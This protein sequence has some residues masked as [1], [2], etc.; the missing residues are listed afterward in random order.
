MSSL[1]GQKI[2]L[3][4][5]FFRGSFKDLVYRK[6]ISKLF[7]PPYDET[8]SSLP[9][10]KDL[11][12]EKINS[13][14]EIYLIQ[15]ES[16]N[17]QEFQELQ[18]FRQTFTGKITA[19]YPQFPPD[20]SRQVMNF[21][22]SIIT[23]SLGQ[24]NSLKG[25]CN[26]NYIKYL[27]SSLAMIQNSKKPKIR[28]DVRIGIILPESCDRGIIRKAVDHLAAEGYIL[29]GLTED[30]IHKGTFREGKSKGSRE[31]VGNDGSKGSD[32]TDRNMADKNDRKGQLQQLQEI[33]RQC[34]IFMI[35]TPKSL[36]DLIKELS[37]CTCV[38][39]GSLES[40]W[41]SICSNVPVLPFDSSN[42][43]DLISISHEIGIPC[44]L[45]HH[46]GK[47]LIKKIKLFMSK[48]DIYLQLQDKFL[49]K[50]RL[51]L[52]SIQKLNQLPDFAIPA[53]SSSLTP[54]NESVNHEIPNDMLM[55]EDFRYFIIPDRLKESE[56]LERYLLPYSCITGIYFDLNVSDHLYLFEWMGIIQDPTVIESKNFVGSLNT[57]KAIFT[58][59]SHIL[60]VVS[61]KIKSL[62]LFRIPATLLIHPA[63][64]L[65]QD[66]DD[67]TDVI[68]LSDLDLIPF[69][70]FPKKCQYR[71]SDV[72]HIGRCQ[73]MIFM[74]DNLDLPLNRGYLSTCLANQIPVILPKDERYFQLLGREYPL[75]WNDLAEIPTL[76]DNL[77]QAIGY[78]QSIPKEPLTLPYFINSICDDLKVNQ[79][80]WYLQSIPKD[81]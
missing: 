64:D 17:L 7:Q 29:I 18:D 61:K 15:L 80:L 34:P 48:A 33:Q 40:L 73:L 78:L 36:S 44:L 60:D 21:F 11:P 58:F 59:S 49:L 68:V 57:C 77:N 43:S 19:I 74:F 13:Y 31:K 42:N 4:Y 32:K 14:S 47:E 23:S 70:N 55:P 51:I 2:L 56:A 1:S 39:S 53:F 76:C 81:R 41:L 72:Y 38:I 62:H 24:I 50:S 65:T 20:L 75:Y 22:D 10:L 12:S 3:I 27:P 8:F 37:K 26:Y 5:S 66:T 6:S 16:G 30:Q 28:S 54:L 45:R 25:V 46:S 71:R 69:Q 79:A 63:Q 9:G 35:Q 67:A 52:G